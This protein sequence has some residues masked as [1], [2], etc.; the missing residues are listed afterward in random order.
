MTAIHQH[1]FDN[2]LTLLAEPHPSA[3]SLAMS[4]LTPASVAVEPDGQLGVAALL[5]EMVC[6]GAGKLDARQHSDAMDFLGVHR[7]TSAGV[8]R[9]GLSATMIGTK[10]P[11]ALPLLT[12][13][14][15]QPMLTAESLEPSR[16][17]AL[18]SL[19]ALEDEPQE[20]V[21]IELRRRQYPA[22]FGRS[23]LGVREHIE[24]ITIE[25]V[26][27]YWQQTMTPKGSII[28]FAG[29]FNW[30]QLKDQVEQLLGDWKGETPDPQIV[31]DPERGYEHQHAESAQ[32]HI[33]L[34][35]DALPETDERSILQR[36]SIAVLDGGMSARL[37]TEVREKRG[38]C[39][40]VYAT[41]A[42]QRDRGAILSYSGTTA[43]RAQETLDVLVAEHNRLSEGIEQDE[44]DR[45]LV[46][47]KS[48]IVMQGESTGARA[49]SIAADQYTRGHPRTLDELAANV[50]GVTLDGLNDFI[51]S[52]KPGP[53][54]IVTVGPKPLDV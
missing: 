15:R 12:D 7:S 8:N 28:S 37:F 30:N 9:F 22:P 5:E 2:G 3:Q 40:A 44:F 13:M 11:D 27:E 36:A 49:R 4:F 26:R 51:K 25:Q 43:E 47:M 10:L 21:F 45:A 41:Y 42:G 14:V 50:D 48:R 29:A 17:L 32:V 19:D 54:S 39:Y 1:T 38:L 34:A 33:G 53:M 31:S 16:D 24:A 6:R 20:K 23:S 18:Q 52:H 35:Y 46:G